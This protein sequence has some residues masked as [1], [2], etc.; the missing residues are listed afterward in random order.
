M[1]QSRIATS[2]MNV[3]VE[4]SAADCVSIPF[5]G[6]FPDG[7]LMGCLNTDVDACPGCYYVGGMLRVGPRPFGCGFA[8]NGT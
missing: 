6:F 3:A 4:F 2:G 5:R 7:F 1:R 8:N